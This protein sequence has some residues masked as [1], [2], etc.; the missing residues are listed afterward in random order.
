M[1][2][3]V[4]ALFLGVLSWVSSLRRVRLMF[5]LFFEDEED[6]AKAKV[7]EINENEKQR[8]CAGLPKHTTSHI[9]Y[10]SARVMTHDHMHTAY[11]FNIYFCLSKL[12]NMG[13]WNLLDI[14]HFV[15]F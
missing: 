15:A 4:G 11:F 9:H 1:V 5:L 13:S 2:Y 10:G 8:G 7:A 14:L 12:K 3:G 6:E